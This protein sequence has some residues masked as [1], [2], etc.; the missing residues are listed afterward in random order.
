MQRLDAGHALSLTTGE[1]GDDSD[2]Q[3]GEHAVGDSSEEGALRP[4]SG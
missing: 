3:E 4:G 2:D 1:V